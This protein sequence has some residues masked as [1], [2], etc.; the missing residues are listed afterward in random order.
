MKKDVRTIVSFGNVDY[1][2]VTGNDGMATAG[3]G[4]VLAGMIAGYLAQD[5]DPVMASVMGCYLHGM[6]GDIAA[7]VKGARA[8]IASD[9]MEEIPVVLELCK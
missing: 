3:S 4:D 6:A 8:V 5:R 1:I 2:N 7:K 9:I